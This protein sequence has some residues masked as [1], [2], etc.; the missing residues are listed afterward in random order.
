MP[1]RPLDHVPGV[2]DTVSAWVERKQPKPPTHEIAPEPEEPA[3]L[4]QSWQL[5][6]PLERNWFR[7]TFQTTLWAFLGSN[8]LSL[9]DTMRTSE[10]RARM[11]AAFGE[12]TQ[13]V[14]DLGNVRNLQREEYIQFEYWFVLNDTIPLLV[15]DV[16]GP[17]ERGVV[18]ATDQRYRDQ[19]Y[20]LRDTF[21]T[22]RIADGRRE[23]FV[24][25]YY[26]YDQRTWYRTGYDGVRFFRQR[27]GP[28]NL[29][30]GRPTLN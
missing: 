29:T 9:I 30:R 19:L 18:V 3:E 7:Q 21:L 4:V 22:Q 15:I 26:H 10:V 14:A 11:A 27:I 5:I 24:D 16:N 2:A 23:L 12:P 8:S 13:T 6:K 20:D 17:F 25:Y 28:P 1:V